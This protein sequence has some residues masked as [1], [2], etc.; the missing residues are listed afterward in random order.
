M[1]GRLRLSRSIIE[2]ERELGARWQ[3]ASAKR[4]SC[5]DIGA[6]QRFPVVRSGSPHAGRTLDP[7]H[8]GFVVTRMNSTMIV[9]TSIDCWT[10]ISQT[11]ARGASPWSTARRCLVPCDCLYEWQTEARSVAITSATDGVMTLG[12]I[13]GQRISAM[14]D[15]LACFAVLVTGAKKPLTPICRRPPV[16]I[17][18]EARGAWLGEEAIDIDRAMKLLEPCP[19]EIVIVG[20]ADRHRPAAAMVMTAAH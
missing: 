20:R 12:G 1:G 18:P 10:A 3:G 17:P 5:W 16:V 9:S 19:A 4:E 2:V 11:R 14:G 13:W 7:M 6:G 15:P 8:W